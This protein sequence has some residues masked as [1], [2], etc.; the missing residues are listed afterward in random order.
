MK[1]SYVNPTLIQ[2]G[3]QQIAALSDLIAKDQK[4]L[5]VYGG[6]S[7]KKNGVYD[8]V[9]AALEGFDWVEFSGVGANPTI[10]VLDQA[11]KICKEQDIDFVLGVGGGSV[12]D[13]VKYIAASAVY[14]GEGWDIPTGKHTITSALP[15]GAILTLPATGSESNQNSVVSKEATKQKLPFASPEVLPKFAI[16]DPDVMKTL[17]QRQLVNGLVDAWV[18]TCEQ[19]LTFPE[20]ALVQEGYAEALLRTLKTLGDNFENQDDAWRANL[21]WAANQALN[22]LIGSG[23]SQD[24]ATHMIG[25]ELTAAYGVDHARSLAIVQ[26]SLLRNQFAVKKAKLEQM[27]KNVFGLEQSED[28]AEKTI[29]AIE[30]FYH[31]LD[32]A[33]Q[34][35][36]HGDDKAAA[37]DN[38]IGKLEAHGMVALGENQAITLKESREILEQAVA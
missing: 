32:V 13:G 34:L 22:G 11:V 31:S 26:P 16:M 21:M 36:E 7:I 6:G 3:Q 2:F 30:A 33:T 15:I 5:V 9:A 14:D 37:I 10:E 18:H 38:I 27:G 25:H 19:Y 23:V 28:L 29:A 1:F 17:P 12:I 4:V 20:T 24:W 8:Q 35:T